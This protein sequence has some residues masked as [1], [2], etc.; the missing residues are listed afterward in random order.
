MA[1]IPRLRVGD[2][3]LSTAVKAS[4]SHGINIAKDDT[5]DEQ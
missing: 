5:Q 3:K 1:S 4:D 2:R